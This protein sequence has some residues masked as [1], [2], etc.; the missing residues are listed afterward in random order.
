MT[1]YHFNML[2]I[3]KDEYYTQG[4][5]LA[6]LGQKPTNRMTLARSP[7]KENIKYHMIGKLKTIR[8]S[9][10]KWLFDRIDRT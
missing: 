6:L 3:P 2:N 1:T 9:Q 10:N 7:Y 8:K 5:I 4:H